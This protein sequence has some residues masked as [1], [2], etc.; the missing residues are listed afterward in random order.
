M[1][2]LTWALK[3]VDPVDLHRQSG[4]HAHEIQEQLKYYAILGQ[5]CT[6]RKIHHPFFLAG[7]WGPLANGSLCLSTPKHNGKSGTVHQVLTFHLLYIRKVKD[8]MQVIR[9]RKLDDQK[10]KNKRTNNDVPTRCS[11]N[12]SVRHTKPK[13]NIYVYFYFLFRVARSFVLFCRS[14]FIVLSVLLRFTGSDYPFGI[15]SS[16]CSLFICM[17]WM[18]L[19]VF[20]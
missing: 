10:K 12:P 4:I 1:R 18:L 3:E 13:V 6:L 19:H 20:T 14:L 17:L 16:S 8:T 9:R 5:T 15:F 7:R 11:V 2:P